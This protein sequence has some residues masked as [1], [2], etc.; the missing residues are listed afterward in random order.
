MTA[1]HLAAAYGSAELAKVLLSEL[2]G[3]PSELHRAVDLVEKRLGTPISAA[4]VEGHTALIDLLVGHGADVN[5]RLGD[6]YRRGTAL[7]FA[8]AHDQPLAVEC[9]IKHGVDLDATDTAGQT[10]LHVCLGKHMGL[11]TLRLL[12][13]AGADVN[14]LILGATPL[15]Q[16]VVT[17][18]VDV[19][20]AVLDAG[21]DLE[22]RNGHG[23]TALHCAI[24]YGSP[25]SPASLVEELIGRG[26]NVNVE[27]DQNR[28]TPLVHAIVAGR[29]D[30]ARLLLDSGAN[31]NHQGSDRNTLLHLLARTAD[32][33]GEWELALRVVKGRLSDEQDAAQSVDEFRSLL[34]ARDIRDQTALHCAAS[35]GNL[36][37]VVALLDAGATIEPQDDSCLT[38]LSY[39]AGYDHSDVVDLLISRGADEARTLTFGSFKFQLPGGRFVELIVP[40]VV[41]GKSFGYEE[42]E[43]TVQQFLSEADVV[44]DETLPPLRFTLPM[45]EPDET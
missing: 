12:L 2:D 7:H 18:D 23:F 42:A 43:S 40:P 27:A 21:A 16:S 37:A 26:A 39:A 35:S 36:A 38:P 14:K 1:L 41:D 45:A 28:G 11:Q 22:K 8:V 32:T 25:A 5:Q 10:A 30:L 4:C 19:V 15:M 34:D 3:D 29:E 6:K 44:D 24:L 17:G 33:G 20:R 9:L 13:A 31:I